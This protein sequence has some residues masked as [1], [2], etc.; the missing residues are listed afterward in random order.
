[1][2]ELSID[3]FEDF[4]SPFDGR[5]NTKVENVIFC[6][7]LLIDRNFSYP[8]STTP[9]GVHSRGGES[10]VRV[11]LHTESSGTAP[12]NVKTKNLEPRCVNY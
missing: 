12:Y 1:M 6:A 5:I 10:L 3:S 2:Y 9:L 11:L 4:P 8:S 7:R